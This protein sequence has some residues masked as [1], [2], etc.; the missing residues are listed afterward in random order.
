MIDEENLRENA[1]EV[2]GYLR[3]RLEEF[4]AR[5]AR[6]AA[7]SGAGLFIDLEI[8]GEAEPLAERL[9]PTALVE[10]AAPDR[11]AIRPPLC[12]SRDAADRFL[13]RLE[14]LLSEM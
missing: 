4:A 1:R 9:R 14:N 2:G 6:L 7:V 10:V 3:A 12:L 5:F 11:I 8:S 13:T